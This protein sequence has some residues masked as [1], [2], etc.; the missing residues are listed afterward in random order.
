MREF[1]G[2]KLQA[3]Q[4]SGGVWTIGIGHTPAKK[5]QTITQLEADEMFRID[6]E[7]REPALNAMLQGVPTK[8][9]EYDALLSLGFNIGMERLRGS[10]AMKRHKMG[11]KTGA[12]NAFL[13]WRFVAGKPSGGLMR[14]REKERLV[15]LGEA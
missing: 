11:N 9:C 10:T 7:D 6:I 5:G 3:Y 2:C 15:Y 1:E 8:Q 4:D 13:L 14:R 12:A